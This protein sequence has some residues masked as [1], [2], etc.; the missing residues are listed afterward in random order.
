MAG[1]LTALTVLLLLIAVPAQA[2][3]Q[4]RTELSGWTEV[5]Y[6]DVVTGQFG[7]DREPVFEHHCLDDFT[8]QIAVR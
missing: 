2:P 6:V 7:V 8:R 3:D 4:C 5:R 1:L